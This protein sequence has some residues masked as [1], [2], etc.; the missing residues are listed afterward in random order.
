MMLKNREHVD[1]LEK[2]CGEHAPC[3]SIVANTTGFP[4]VQAEIN[5]AIIQVFLDKDMDIL[6][7]TMK[8]GNNYALTAFKCKLVDPNGA[9]ACERKVGLLLSAIGLEDL[10]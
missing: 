8:M 2:Y 9:P 6:T 5:R 10:T 7:I 3:F 4:Y 1:I